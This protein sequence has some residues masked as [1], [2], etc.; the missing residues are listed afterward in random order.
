[1][2]GFGGPTSPDEIRPFLDRVL[3]GRPLPRERYEEVVRHYEAFG[4]RSPYN[5]L[6]MRQAAAL[7]EALR[8]QGIDIPVA[9]GMRN[10]PPYIEDALRELSARGVKRALGFI[11]AAH[12]CE[13]SWDQYQRDGPKRA[14]ASAQPHRRSNIPRHG[15]GIRGLSRRRG[16]YTRGL[17]ATAP[18]PAC[19]GRLVFTAHSIPVAMAAR[20]VRRSA[21]ETAQL[22]AAELGIAIVDPRVS[23]PQR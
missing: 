15:T 9:V 1:M 16:S 4:G 22:V 14:A 6:T 2:I 21:N 20:A 13:S 10:A 7:R 8:T 5:E 23:K 19:G 12:R 18:G 11:L 3:N 17:C